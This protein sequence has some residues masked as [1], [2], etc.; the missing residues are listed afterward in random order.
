MGTTE[1]DRCYHCQRQGHFAREC[2]RKL[3][4]LPAVKRD[5]NKVIAVIEADSD[6]SDSGADATVAAI[7]AIKEAPRRV[8]FTS[9]DKGR[10][11]SPKRRPTQEVNASEGTEDDEKYEQCVSGTEVSY[12]DDTDE[13]EVASG[14][15]EQ[16]DS[17]TGGVETCTTAAARSGMY[18][19]DDADILDAL[20]CGVSFLDLRYRFKRTKERRRR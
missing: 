7:N 6:S 8:R 4:G 13:P 16:R 3:A 12:V 9:K 5:F 17:T 18:S 2:T 15:S 14:D 19:M 1:N 20:E 11:A 10:R